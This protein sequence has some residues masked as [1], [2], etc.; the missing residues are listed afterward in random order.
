MRAVLQ[1]YFLAATFVQA[2]MYSL[3]EIRLLLLSDAGIMFGELPI[4]L[5][6]ITPGY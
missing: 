2:A 3:R 5:R 1:S 4:S 6:A